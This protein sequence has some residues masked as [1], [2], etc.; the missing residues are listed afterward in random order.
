MK[1]C[2]NLGWAMLRP[3]GALV[4]QKMSSVGDV[5]DESG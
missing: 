5:H 1:L 2:H 4:V 3:N